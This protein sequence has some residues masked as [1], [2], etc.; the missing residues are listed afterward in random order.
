LALLY[1]RTGNDGTDPAVTLADLGVI[2]PTGAGWTLLSAS[3]PEDALGGGGQFTA[4]EIRDSQDLHD[5]ITGGSL[6]WSKN[7]ST[8]ELAGAY[9]AD[10]MLMEDFT[11]DD[12]VPASITLSGLDIGQDLSDH[13]NGGPNKHDASEIDVEGTYSNIPSSPTDLE[14]VI[15]ELNSAIVAGTASF[16]TVTGD[17]GSAAADI[18]NDTLNIAGSN[19]IVTSATDNPEVLTVDGNLLLPRDGSRPMTGNLDLGSNDITN[20]SNI[21]ASGLVDLS[22]GQFKLPQAADVS[23]SFPGG[24]E[25]DLAWDTDDEVLYAHDGTQWFALAPASGII[26]DHG[27]LTGLL[28]DDHTQYPLLSGARARNDITGVIDYGSDGDLILPTGTPGATLVDTGAAVEG[29]VKSVSGT[30]ALYDGTRAKWLSVNRQIYSAAKKSSASDVYLRGPDGVSHL[31]SG[32]GIGTNCAIVGL[33]V[34]C[35]DAAT[36]T[37]EVRRNDSA[38]VLAS[39]T[40]T[41]ATSNSDM[42]LNADVASGDELQLYIN[43]SCKSPHVQLHLAERF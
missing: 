8:E 6:E 10:Y 9:R 41:A 20:V 16:G 36:F 21:T 29:A 26:T 22:A 17:T 15:S 13:L 24:S 32:I 40:V 34:E 37:V 42:T 11:D 19:G 2:I 39:V 31:E 18:A 33:T 35:D 28:D 27:G 4:R 7:G 14:T 1:V 43:G 5:A 25:G 30:L 38:T 23:T 3:N 12:L